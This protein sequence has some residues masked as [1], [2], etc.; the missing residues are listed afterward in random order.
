MAEIRIVVNSIAGVRLDFAVERIADGMYYRAGT[1][2][3]APAGAAPWAEMDRDGPTIRSAALPSMD[4]GQAY[5]FHVIE[6]H[7]RRLVMSQLIDNWGRMLAAPTGGWPAGRQPPR[8]E[9]RGG[10]T[11]VDSRQGR[12]IDLE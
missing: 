10:Y 1:G 2:W 7:T 11:I 6:Y 12:N 9:Y 3:V 5:C 4:V 8:N